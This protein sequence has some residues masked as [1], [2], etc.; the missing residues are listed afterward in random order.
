MVLATSSVA[1]SKLG[2]TDID[3][4]SEAVLKAA[5]QEAYF[6]GKEEFRQNEMDWLRIEN[7]LLKLFLCGLVLYH[8]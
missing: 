7:T 1:S 8:K 5:T 6:R 4:A 3:L 2:L